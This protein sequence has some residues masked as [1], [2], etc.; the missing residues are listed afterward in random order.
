MRTSAVRLLQTRLAELG[1]YHDDIDGQRGSNTHAAVN[2]AL[3]TRSRD[4]PPGWRGWTDKRKSIGFLQLWCHDENIDAG[5]ID[6]RWGPQTQF[7]F[8][9]LSEVVGRLQLGWQ[10]ETGQV[11]GVLMPTVYGIGQFESS[12]PDDR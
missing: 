9:A 5:D 7:A 3:A 6:G 8:D 4:M 12:R 11:V 10:S 2:A 1:H